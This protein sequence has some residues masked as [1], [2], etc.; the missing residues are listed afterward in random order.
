MNRS[1]NKERRDGALN[2]A[3]NGI[4]PETSN[5]DLSVKV[6]RTNVALRHTSYGSERPYGRLAARDTLWAGSSD[7]RVSLHFTR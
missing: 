2:S 3:T 1:A 5:P 4:T 6:S 7:P